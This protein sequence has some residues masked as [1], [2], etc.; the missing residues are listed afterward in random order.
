MTQQR[1]SP[2][3]ITSILPATVTLSVQGA[4]GQSFDLM[5][6]KN[7]AGGVLGYISNGGAIGT[8][9]RLE[10]GGFFSTAAQSTTQTLAAD[11]IGAIIR[12]ASAMTA[13]LQQWQNSAGTVLSRVDNAGNIISLSDSNQMYR[14]N[15]TDLLTCGINFRLN[16]GQSLGSGSRVMALGNALTVPSVNPTNGGILYVEAGALKYR[17]SSGTVTTIANA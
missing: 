4:L 14:L 2:V 13:D 7:N 11:R 15:V 16:A 8:Y 17:G 9:G 10:V 3:S 12:G 6:W 5:Q 1:V